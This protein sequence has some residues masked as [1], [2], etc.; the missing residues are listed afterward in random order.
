MTRLSRGLVVLMVAALSGCGYAL[1][2]RGNT[3]PP[4]LSTIGVPAFIN[5]SATPD[6]DRILTEAVRTEWQGKGKYRVLPEEGGVDAVLHATIVSVTLQPVAFTTSNQVSRNL[7]I[8][9]ASVEFKEVATSKVIWANPSFQVRDEFEVTSGTSPNDANAL[10]SQ[11]VN[12]MERIG[13]N[14]ARSVVTSVFE[15]F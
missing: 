3:L 13:R 14:F 9:T 10:F 12:A 7:I 15:A 1:S 2:G 8:V 6:I 4:G 11:N 5:H